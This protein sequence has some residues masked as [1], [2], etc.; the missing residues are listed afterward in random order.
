MGRMQ[1]LGVDIVSVLS[2]LDRRSGNRTLILQLVTTD[3][4]D[5]IQS[6]K[7]GGYEVSWMA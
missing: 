6:L 1:D 3:P 7:T 4:S 5:V 2:D